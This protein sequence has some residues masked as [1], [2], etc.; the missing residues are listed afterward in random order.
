MICK[1]YPNKYVEKDTKQQVSR[2]SHIYTTQEKKMKYKYNRC[3]QRR[4]AKQW[5]RIITKIGNSRMPLEIKK[6]VLKSHI[7]RA[8]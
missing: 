8:Q 5:N 3:P 2:G 6:Y 4:K 1:L 7:E